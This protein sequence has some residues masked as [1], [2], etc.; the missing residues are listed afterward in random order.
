MSQNPR[1]LDAADSRRRSK[2]R[3]RCQLAE[4]GRYTRVLGR[5]RGERA[6]EAPLTVTQAGSQ[7]GFGGVR[8]FGRAFKRCNGSTPTDVCPA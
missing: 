6:G 2:R 7:V 8:E 3:L 1:L 5:L 4:Q